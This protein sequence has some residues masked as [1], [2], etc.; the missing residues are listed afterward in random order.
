MALSSSV[1]M[2]LGYVS[3]VQNKRHKNITF[4]NLKNHCACASEVTPKIVFK[5]CLIKRQFS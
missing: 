3:H 2:E 5:H 4:F 1:L